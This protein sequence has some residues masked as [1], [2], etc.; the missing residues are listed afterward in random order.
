MGF[1][2]WAVGGKYAGRNAEA[3]EYERLRREAAERTR[4]SQARPAA[5]ASS[6]AALAS[7]GGGRARV[8]PSGYANA[9]AGEGKRGSDGG[10]T[11][12]APTSDE[13]APAPR[14]RR[15]RRDSC[16]LHFTAALAFCTPLY[17]CWV[18]ILAQMLRP[19]N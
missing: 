1:A 5:G 4:R 16:A 6:N 11:S 19:F 17:D 10:G 13:A 2:A 3:K 15:A 18:L 12:S 7:P 9:Q 8:L 14:A